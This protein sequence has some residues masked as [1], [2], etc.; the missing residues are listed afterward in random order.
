MALTVDSLVRIAASGGGLIIDCKGFTVDSLVRIALA[1][2]LKG[3]KIT[4][5]NLKG[6]TVDSL[7]RIGSAGEGNIV[8]DT[9]KE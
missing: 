1:T 5:T 6:F 3:A 8:L 7:V 9:S 4:F 2:K